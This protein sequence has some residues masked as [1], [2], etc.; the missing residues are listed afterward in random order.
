MV[1]AQGSCCQNIF[2]LLLNLQINIFREEGQ[3]GHYPCGC[4]S[5]RKR[6]RSQSQSESPPHKSLNWDK[7]SEHA[8]GKNMERHGDRVLS[9]EEG[10][11]RQHPCGRDSSRKRHRSQSQS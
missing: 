8:S 2:P 11:T 3:T 1:H 7:E 4:D 5:S 6:H 9:Q 10:Q